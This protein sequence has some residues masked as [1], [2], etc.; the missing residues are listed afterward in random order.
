[1]STENFRQTVN[2][3]LCSGGKIVYNNQLLLTMN[4]QM[5]VVPSGQPLGLAMVHLVMWWTELVQEDLV[6]LPTGIDD[7]SGSVSQPL[8]P[9]LTTKL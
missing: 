9:L 3:L 6:L 1:M 2:N 8:Y 4:V 7:M 5:V